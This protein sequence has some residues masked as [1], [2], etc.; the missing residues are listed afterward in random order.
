MTTV[1]LGYSVKFFMIVY[2]VLAEYGIII[3][4]VSVF[5]VSKVRLECTKQT[6]EKMIFMYKTMY[7]RVANIIFI[8]L[9]NH[10]S[11]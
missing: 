2:I 11:K 1:L 10:S 4:S 5:R 9:N 8:D 3:L 7:Q 6:I